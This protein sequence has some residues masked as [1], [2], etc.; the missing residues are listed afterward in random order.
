MQH[1]LTRLPDRP[2]PPGVQL[3]ALSRL[4]RLAL[5]DSDLPAD[6]YGVLTS[7]PNLRHLSL[8]SVL[9]LPAALRQLTALR[10]FDL[11]S[12]GGGWWA[13]GGALQDSLQAMPHLTA[14]CLSGSLPTLPAPGAALPEGL[15]LLLDTDWHPVFQ[16]AHWPASLRAVVATWPQLLEQPLGRDVAPKLHHLAI[17]PSY[18]FDWG[19]AA[20]QPGWAALW[21]W[22]EHAPDLRLLEVRPRGACARAA[23]ACRPRAQHAAPEHAPNHRQPRSLNLP[24]T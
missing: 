7:L 2:L 17:Q 24:S 23:P 21:A 16:P 20:R 3:S 14:L 5:S 12:C 19:R 9:A 11:E 1:Q 13:P 22:L 18:S 4:Q 6:G 15:Q 10:R 8:C